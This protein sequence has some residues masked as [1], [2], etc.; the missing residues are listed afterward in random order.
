MFFFKQELSGLVIGCLPLDVDK[1]GLR[2]IL[3]K[4]DATRG[5]GFAVFIEVVVPVFLRLY[6]S[7]L[8]DFLPGSVLLSKQ[9][10]LVIAIDQADVN[11]NSILKS[12]SCKTFSMEFGF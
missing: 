5:E 6:L 10:N 9:S 12:H 4:L 1:A 2:N 7:C 11:R 3:S 8:C